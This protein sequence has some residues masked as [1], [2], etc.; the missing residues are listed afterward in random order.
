MTILL[1]FAVYTTL[2][3]NLQHIVHYKSAL[4]LHISPLLHEKKSKTIKNK[5]KKKH[6]SEK[7]STN[8]LTN[9]NNLWV[10]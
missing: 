7:L 5:T 1:S 10:K 2:Q 8:H 9:F 4:S 3:Y 6:D